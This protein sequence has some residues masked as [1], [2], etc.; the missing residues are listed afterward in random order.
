MPDLIT[1]VETDAF[2]R[3]AER[4]LVESE[5]DALKDFLAADP[6]AGVVI[7]GTGGVRKLR[8]AASG[9][10]KR[11]G[12]R[13]IYYYYDQRMP[14]FLIAFFQKAVKADLSPNEKRAARQLAEELV[15]QFRPRS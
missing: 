2:M 15:R 11:G 9:R 6:E 8:W 10:G 7:P 5:R 14:L 1:I 4:A 13:V 3:H 12:G